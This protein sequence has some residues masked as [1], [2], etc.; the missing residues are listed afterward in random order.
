MGGGEY[1]KRAEKDRGEPGGR[2]G[3]CRWGLQGQGVAGSG[4]FR[5]DNAAL[6]WA[7]WSETVVPHSSPNK[8]GFFVLFCFALRECGWECGWGWG[9]GGGA[10][11]NPS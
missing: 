9:L 10:Q 7:N 3:I 5:T 8:T 4:G 6:H 11:K 1:L 2:K